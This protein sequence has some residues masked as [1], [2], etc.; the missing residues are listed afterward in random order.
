MKFKNNGWHYNKHDSARNYFL[1]GLKQHKLENYAAAIEYYSSALACDLMSAGSYNNRGIA[2]ASILHYESAISDFN[3]C[4]A[5]DS[6]HPDVYSNLALA[7]S[8]LNYPS[9]EIILDCK[10]AILIDSQ[11]IEAY[12][13]LGI[14]Y[15]SQGKFLEAVLNFNLALNIN[16]E[17]AEAYN[18]R[19]N[20]YWKLGYL[21]QA[22]SDFN[23]A[24]LIN[25][26]YAEAYN[27]RGSI[28]QSLG[29]KYQA[30][31]DYCMTIPYSM[32][33]LTTK[34]HYVKVLELLKFRKINDNNLSNIQN[35][36]IWFAHPDQFDDKEDGKY[37]LKLYPKH[38]VIKQTVYSVLVYSCFGMFLNEDNSPEEVLAKY[39]NVMWTDYGD[40]GRGICLHYQYNPE[41]AAKVNK[42]SFDKITYVEN[43]EN[44]NQEENI[45]LFDTIQ[46]GFFT[47]DSGFNFENEARFITMADEDSKTG[48]RIKE[49]DL[50][51]TLIA[52]DFGFDCRNEDKLKVMDAVNAR[53]QKT[54]IEFFQLS[55]ANHGLFGFNK[56]KIIR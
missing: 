51:L 39:Q 15:G 14:E 18:N 12:S 30:I 20:V 11:N 7:K 46:H 32:G 2:K 3:S 5:I 4:I 36:E 38:E 47:K 50:G 1:L 34:Q 24:I 42:F 6:R 8:K 19:G 29:L 52:I 37:L 28:N 53:D 41:Q 31:A 16:P 17:F 10:Q 23:Q 49:S 44:I 54:T 27:N 35:G 22:T 21:N 40:S 43:L 13:L 33:L 25:P 9:H 26:R 55:P 45:S 56:T 48:K